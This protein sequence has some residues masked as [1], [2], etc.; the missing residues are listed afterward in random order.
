MALLKQAPGCKPR[1]GKERVRPTPI[2]EQAII[3]AGIGAALTGMRPVAE[4]MFVDFAG[5]CLDQI[6]NHAAKQRY[7]SGGATHV[8]MTIRMIA[9]GGVGGLVCAAF[10]IARI[11]AGAHAGVESRLSQYGR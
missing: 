1:F 2:A 9:G 8:P 11:L 7:M 6:A 5:V 4:I 10:A 3:G